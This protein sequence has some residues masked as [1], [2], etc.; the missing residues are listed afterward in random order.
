MTVQKNLAVKR[1]YIESLRQKMNQLTQE[2][3]M[4]RQNSSGYG[5]FTGRMVNDEQ[6]DPDMV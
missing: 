1:K 4:L 2:A 6:M 3:I 5:G